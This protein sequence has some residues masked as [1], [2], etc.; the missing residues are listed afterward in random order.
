M[1][2]EKTITKIAQ[3]REFQLIMGYRPE[4]DVGR[5]L[6]LIDAARSYATYVKHKLNP[7]YEGIDLP[8]V[9]ALWSWPWARETF[10][11]N[12]SLDDILVESAA[13]LAAATDALTLEQEL[14]S[15]ESLRAKLRTE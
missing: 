10:N 7:Q 3:R 11:V 15:L 9:A 12:R 13:L 6:E 5:A 8:K 2:P 1:N 14:Q 4:G